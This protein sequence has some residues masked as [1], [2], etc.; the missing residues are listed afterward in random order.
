MTDIIKPSVRIVEGIL[1]DVVMKKAIVVSTPSTPERETS[2]LL[3]EP[4]PPPRIAHARAYG[5]IAVSFCQCDLVF[6][7][8]DDRIG[9]RALQTC[10]AAIGA[11]L[12]ALALTLVP[13]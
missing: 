9:R 12:A 7:D 2:N 10:C 6:V 8:W 13:L 5:H 3:K 11:A 1:K 4:P